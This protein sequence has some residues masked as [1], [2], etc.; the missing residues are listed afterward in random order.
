MAPPWNAESPDQASNPS[1]YPDA[2]GFKFNRFGVRVPMMMMSPWVDSG[3]VFRGETT[4]PPL[5]HTSILATVLDWKSLDRN[6]LDSKRVAKA[7]NLEFILNETGDTPAADL[8]D[9]IVPTPKTDPLPGDFP[10]T[11]LQRGIV[12]SLAEEKGGK[13]A[14]EAAYKKV[15]TLDELE[16]FLADTK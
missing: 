9:V 6:K 16:A 11:D 15:K 4:G 14:A 5:D 1:K 7:Q 8:T 2:Q 13:E 3:I 10:I 12:Y